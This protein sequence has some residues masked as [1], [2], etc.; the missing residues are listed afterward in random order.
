MRSLP[1]RLFLGPAALLLSFA[2]R[3][4]GAGTVATCDDASFSA[5]L[6]GGGT[7]TFAC[8]GTIP[9]AGAKSITSATTVD[10]AGHAVTLQGGS[11]W[12]HFDVTSPG[13]LTLI[14][15]TLS[16]GRSPAGNGGSID[17]N[18]GNV[19]LQHCSFSD[20]SAVWSGDS[21]VDSTGGAVYV[22]GATL[23][24][25][26]SSFSSNSVKP[27]SGAYGGSGLVGR[28]GSG[29][30]I[31]TLNATV[32]VRRSVFV[33]NSATGGMAGCPDFLMS[34]GKAGGIGQGGAIAALGT[35][36]LTI[37][38][39]RFF[40]NRATGGVGV[41]TGDYGS[42][43]GAAK[44]GALWF[45]TSGSVAGTVF[46]G[47]LA[48]GADGSMGLYPSF[49]GIGGLAY[50]GA[51]AGSA[52][53]GGFDSTFAG[54]SA[55]PGRDG[56]WHPVPVVGTGT[57]NAWHSSSTGTTS[58]VNDAFWANPTT[59]AGGN[60]VVA[61]GT[62]DLR[63][64]IVEGGAAGTGNVSG[65]PLF[66]SLVG[67]DGIVGTLDD[68]VHASPGSSAIDA[69]SNADVP[70]GVTTTLD[71]T[72]RFLDDPGTPDSGAGSPPLVDIGAFEFPT[73]CIPLPTPPAP[74]VSA[75]DCS[76]FATVSWPVAPQA[77]VYELLR[78]EGPCGTPSVRAETVGR[79]VDDPVLPLTEY[80]WAL[81]YLDLCGIASPV[82]PCTTLTTPTEVPAVPGTP[83]LDPQCD[84]V[85]VSWDP[86]QGATDYDVY[87]HSGAGTYLCDSLAGWTLRGSSG[88]IPSFLDPAVDG[89]TWT[90]RVVARSSCG[91]SA[92]GSCA[93]VKAADPPP[94][95]PSAPTLAPT[96]SSV[97]V[98]W[99]PASGATS[100]DVYRASGSSCTGGT[101]ISN[102]TTRTYTD[103][104]LADGSTW[105]YSIVARGD[106]GVSAPSACSTIS[107]GL[108]PPPATTT[109]TANLSQCNRLTV[110]W[111]AVSGATGYAV[112]R[113]TGA[114]CDSPV[115][116][117]TRSTIS[118][119]DTSVSQ[120]VTYSYV[121]YAL[122][123]CGQSATP[124]PCA[125]ATA[126]APP[127]TSPAPSQTSSDCSSIGLAWA[128]EPLAKNYY[129]YKAANATCA[130]ATSLTFTSAQS[131]TA[132]GLAP[133][134]TYSFYLIAQNACGSAAASA[135]VTATTAPPPAVDGSVH[136]AVSG[137]NLV[138]TWANVPGATSYRVLADSSPNGSF[139]TQLG[140][141]SSGTTGLTLPMPAQDWFRVAALTSCGW[142]AP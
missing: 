40:G 111:A 132:T 23:V 29:G 50:G 30:A 112:Y 34:H 52:A 36:S 39:C 116:L 64:S 139:A 4:E 28:V 60:D 88:F 11:T 42:Y 22:S 103:S 104:G 53:V 48:T 32:T 91:E 7:V 123:S 84:G 67:D 51:V 101:L 110:G 87:R 125:S 66:V 47:N 73:S 16:G 96:C 24:V 68:D 77:A 115:F 69:G 58:L 65:D 114:S 81:R 54:N 62:L 86:V 109:A 33:G 118:Y 1:F 76:G 26:D 113:S 59:L 15:L 57:G 126:P 130:S 18:G 63:Y 108:L 46:T 8:D 13:S 134:T 21:T 89:L 83:L 102:Q 71:G 44:G 80:S 2:P 49:D 119:P 25:E 45:S 106:C 136:L 72:A 79:S 85:H 12:R 3:S 93:F 75:V 133:A 107:V 6:A 27:G 38:D 117:G 43:G 121:V 9:L 78:T 41:S 142:S 20:D 105:S 74:S 141:A 140:T 31:G 14:G 94:P 35:G 135:C 128:A 137:P 56:Y 120:G 122:N 70:A 37:E 61:E 19:T 138:I 82:G 10:A 17:S 92:G 100:Y 55:T 5:A 95:A 131:Y 124:S 90:Y 97:T 99:N 129:L 127:P 98:S